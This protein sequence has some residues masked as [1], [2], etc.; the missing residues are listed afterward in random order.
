MTSSTVWFVCTDDGW[1]SPI[2]SVLS[3]SPPPQPLII[4]RGT[5]NLSMQQTF[6]SRQHLQLLALDDTR[7]LLTAIGSNPIQVDPPHPLSSLP[8]SSHGLPEGVVQLKKGESVE[9]RAQ[10]HFYLPLS[11]K[12]GKPFTLLSKTLTPSLSVPTHPAPTPTTLSPPPPPTSSTPSPTPKRPLEDEDDPFG[13]S[14]NAYPPD[15]RARVR[16]VLSQER[17]STPPPTISPRPYKQTTL[18]FSPTPPS[19]SPAPRPPAALTFDPSTPGFYSL[20]FP[21][22]CL[23]EGRLDPPIAI[24]QAVKAVRSFLS[25]HSSLLHLVLCE[26]DLTLY[27]TILEHLRTH[28]TDLLPPSPLSERFTL[29]CSSPTTLPPGH[30]SATI[31]NSTDWK[32][33]AIGE[34]RRRAV[35][36]ACDDRLAEWTQKQVGL[37]VGRVGEAYPVKL[38]PCPLSDRGVRVV[39]QAVPPSFNPARSDYVGDVAGE[40]D[41]GLPLLLSTY[42]SAFTAFHSLVHPNTRTER[43]DTAPPPTLPQARGDLPSS[44]TSIPLPSYAY[45]TTAWDGAPP[46]ATSLQMYTRWPRTPSLQRAVWCEDTTCVVIY[47]RYPKARVHLL[48]IPTSTSHSLNTVSDLTSADLSLLGELKIRVEAITDHLSASLHLPRTTDFLVGFHSIPSLEPLHLHVLTSDL[49]SPH[50][51]LKKHWNSFTTNFF[52]PLD[53]VTAQVKEKGQVTVDKGVMNALLKA[54]LRCA[55]PPCRAI[56]ATMPALKQHNATCR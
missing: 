51:K 19:P 28:H 12:A 41:P 56:I 30:I 25:S 5:A 53:D 20:A 46:G 15:K 54:P 26:D 21:C 1:S 35:N 27:P 13:W 10:Q 8:S 48:V 3:S 34:K 31:I 22:L 18:S 33:A 44:L 36:A 6:I 39:V 7:V 4:G 55:R 50:L 2:P 49:E 40:K 37:K 42:T 29:L 43:K 11:A 32:W 45:P 23:G 24:D 52:L 17:P 9:L 14:I 47:D 38:R 16:S